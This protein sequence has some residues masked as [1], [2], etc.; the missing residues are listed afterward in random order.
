MYKLVLSKVFTNVDY[1]ISAKSKY[2]VDA[3]EY[4]FQNIFRIS[5]SF[6]QL[7]FSLFNLPTTF[8]KLF[9]TG[10][11]LRGQVQNFKFFK[12]SIFS[13]NP[14]VMT[15]R[16]SFV[17]FFKKLYLI[18]CLNYT[19]KQFIFLKKFINS[20]KT[21]LKYMM[22]RKAWAYTTKPVK[23]IKRRVLKLLRNL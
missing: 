7:F 18:E 12:R 14:L 22:F 9:S 13:I 23:R 1:L 2:M 16:F 6:K 15:I 3:R 4:S 19:K 8:C 10:V 17:P 21:E 20:I 5:T 11:I